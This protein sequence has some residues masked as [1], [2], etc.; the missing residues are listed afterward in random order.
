MF[1][2]AQEMLSAG[3]GLIAWPISRRLESKSLCKFGSLA[4][5]LSMLSATSSALRVALE[6][7]RPA[8]L[9]R[10]QRALR[11][12]ALVYPALRVVVEENGEHA[13]LGTGELF[14]DCVLH[15]VRAS[16]HERADE[17]TR[18]KSSTLNSS[19]SLELRVSD[20]CVLFRETVA[21]RSHS[22]ASAATANL[23]GSLK[24]I[25]EPLDATLIAAFERGEFH[26]L[27]AKTH[28]SIDGDQSDEAAK[29]K[30]Q[31]RLRRE[32]GWDILAARSVWAFGP[33][34]THGSNCLLDD[35]LPGTGKKDRAELS[36]NSIVQGFLWAAR[37]GPLCD[38]PLRGV[39]TKMT[40]I[41]LADDG[42]AQS[43]SQ[44]VPAARRGVHGAILAAAPRLMEPVFRVHVV[45]A[46]EHVKVVG[47]LLARRRG[48]ITE[49][50]AI[51]GTP[52]VHVRAALPVL[53]S[54]GFETDA[55]LATRG[56]ASVAQILDH[57]QIIPGD[58]LDEN[59][60]L[61]PLEPAP[62]SALAR[63]CLLKTRRRKGLGEVIAARR[64]A[65]DLVG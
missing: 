27:G 54:F 11:Q 30:A 53:D 14:L 44:L 5:E 10:L 41:E 51:A 2:G 56:V 19:S 62:P 49:Q 26:M 57:W 9:P 25:S 46:P 61:R 63:D 36:R 18:A 47:A 8:E 4:R 40:D 22:S 21:S 24:F 42:L 58:P 52:L 34:P 64:F 37:E 13:I 32:F 38:E 31:S 48:Y 6:P 60:V 45:L 17:S 55:R 33:D 3:S 43:A 35:V 50:Q 1:E 59:H 28:F 12:C 29:A 23:S 65:D 15:D 16:A 39:L 20:P 7:L